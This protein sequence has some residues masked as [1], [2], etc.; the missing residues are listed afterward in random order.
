M[1]YIHTDN[2]RKFI[3]LV[4]GHRCIKGWFSGHFHLGQDYQ[5]SITFPTEGDD[6][7]SCVFCQTSVMRDETSR[8]GRR[9]SRLLRGNKNGFEVC[10]VDHAKGGEIRVDATVIYKDDEHEVGVYAH[11]DDEAY[12]HEDYFKVYTPEVGDE[13]HIRGVEDT[14][15]ALLAKEPVDED[16]KAWW[17]LSC[18]RVLGMC[19]G[20]LLEYDSSTLAP[21]GLVISKDELVGKKIAVVESHVHSSSD[22]SSEE[23]QQRDQAVIMYDEEGSVT[24]VQPNEDGSYWRKI[25]RNKVARMAERRREQAAVEFAKLM[26]DMNSKEA[27]QQVL[28]TYGPYIT[29]TGTA[30]T[31]QIIPEKLILSP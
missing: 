12:N 27:K 7:G 14:D 19:N 3:E 21:L 4:R 5:D 13:G 9:Q 18:G 2:C 30:K 10:T 17:R 20:M 22:E 26:F 11:R 31:T 16:C 6:R 15:F 29:T 25:V 28:S 23:E 8:D 24:V 1:P